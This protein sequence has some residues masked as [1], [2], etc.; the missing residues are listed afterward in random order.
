MIPIVLRLGPFTI[1]SYGLMM[2]LGIIAAGVAC[3]SEFKRR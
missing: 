1:Y 2:G 3:T